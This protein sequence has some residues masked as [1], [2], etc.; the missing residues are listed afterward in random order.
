L[1]NFEPK[2]RF[3]DQNTAHSKDF[4][5]QAP[6]P[7]SSETRCSPGCCSRS[8]SSPRTSPRSPSV[9]SASLRCARG[10]SRS[11]HALPR[12]TRP[13]LPSG[14]ASSSQGRPPP[15]R[16]R[17]AHPLPWR[18]GQNLATGSG[19]ST[20]ALS[21]PPSLK[22]RPCLATDCLPRAGNPS[23]P[24]GRTSG[25]CL[26]ARLL[27]HPRAPPR[28]RDDRVGSAVQGHR[29]RHRRGAPAWAAHRRALLGIPPRQRSA[30]P[31]TAR[32]RAAPRA[33][34]AASQVPLTHAPAPADRFAPAGK[35][36]D[37]S[38]S[39]GK[40]LSFS[41][42]TGNVIKGWC[43]PATSPNLFLPLPPP[44]HTCTRP[45]RLPSCT[46]WTRLVLP[47]Y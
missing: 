5:F 32:A 13:P 44:P 20:R 29:G 25:A 12:A 36:F 3:G 47:P 10:P 30:P 34:L 43:A 17:S 35:Q 16:S 33:R 14:A 45:P 15:F 31:H 42:G 41:V 46:K 6:A 2:A 23:L 19:R 40:P 18:P 28:L 11:R 38:Y 1:G 24:R 37:S 7:R 9:P 21:T 8:P 4:I 39:R 26:R 22:A 27:P